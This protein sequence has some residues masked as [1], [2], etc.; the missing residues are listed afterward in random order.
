VSRKLMSFAVNRTLG[1]AD[2]PYAQQI[3]TEWTSGT[4]TLRALIKA[5]V[6]NDTFKF[7]HGEAP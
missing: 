6:K 4:P 7:R 5:I 1:D 3:L 2:A